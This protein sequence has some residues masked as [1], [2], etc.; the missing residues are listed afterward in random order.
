MI[1]RDCFFVGGGWVAP[2]SSD[3]LDVVSPTTE[4]LVGRVPASTGLDMDR[5]VSAARKAFEDGPW[6]H[7]SVKERGEFLLGISEQLKPRAEELARL[8]VDER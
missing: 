8:Q 6:P 3:M 5:A 4:L 7:M 2:E 1:S